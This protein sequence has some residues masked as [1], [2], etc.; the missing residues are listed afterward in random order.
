[1]L[2]S[3]AL[4]A[5]FEAAD[6]AG[7]AIPEDGQQIRQLLDGGAWEDKWPDVPLWSL[8]ALAQHEGLPTRLLD[9]TWD[10]RV[11]TFF[12]A[13]DSLYHDDPDVKELAVWSLA[14][15]DVRFRRAIYEHALNPPD[16][17]VTLVTAPSDRNPNLRAQKGLFTLLV[18]RD[19]SL[20]PWTPLEELPHG[21]GLNLI[22][23]T[24]PRQH[25][26]DLLRLLAI[27]GMNPATVFPDFRGVLDSLKLRGRWQR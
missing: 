14:A 5:F 10:W 9:W 27:D 1:M 4:I 6:E 2:E 17:H 21:H 13:R 20:D 15:E 26:S 23:V 19:G 24:L 3:D 11:A 25:A 16:Y 12:A 22:K 7:L 18:A 8:L